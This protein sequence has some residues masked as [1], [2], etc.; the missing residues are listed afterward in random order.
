V[1]VFSLLIEESNN[2]HS[3]HP[4]VQEKASCD[5]WFCSRTR[6]VCV[7][8]YFNNVKRLAFSRGSFLLQ[9]IIVSERLCCFVLIWDSKAN[10]IM[11]S[12]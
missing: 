2:Q 4:F 12:P 7:V 8:S 5:C 6:S 3:F 10:N 9:S 1:K 11:R